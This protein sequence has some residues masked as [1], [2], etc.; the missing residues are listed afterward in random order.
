M[1]RGDCEKVEEDTKQAL[2]ISLTEL[3]RITWGV[4]LNSKR[5]QSHKEGRDGEVA[6]GEGKDKEE[7]GE[8]GDE[9]YFLYFIKK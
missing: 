2:I 4:P 5:S 1:L 7:K 3:L 8:E 9:S 6:E